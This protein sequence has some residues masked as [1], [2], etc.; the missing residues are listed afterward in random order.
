MKRVFVAIFALMLFAACNPKQAWKRNSI[1]SAE[2]I[3]MEQAKAGKVDTAMVDGLLAD[4]EG[5]AAT[6]P[7]DTMGAVYLFK[8]AD[9]Y[10]YMHKPL[11]S[12]GLYQKIYDNYRAIPK[13]PYALFLQGFI[14]ENE[15]GNT[16]TAKDIYEKFLAEFPNHPIAKDVR[17]TLNNLGKTPEQLIQEFEARNQLD[18]LAKAENK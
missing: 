15:V 12:I 9:F 18:S 14:F 13:R 6:Y 1:E 3:L 5:Y 11:K 7:N 4:Y 10:R 2:K 8:A 16:T 17:V